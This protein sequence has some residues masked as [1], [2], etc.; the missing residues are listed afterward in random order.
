MQ[1]SHYYSDT[2][3]RTG[4][5]RPFCRTGFWQS[6]SD[7]FCSL[8]DIVL[9]SP[10]RGTVVLFFFIR[11]LTD[12]PRNFTLVTDGREAVFSDFPNKCILL[13]KIVQLH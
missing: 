13:M 9:M 5:V 3:S 2:M 12:S 7:P 10:P 8:H 4:V 1:N 11:P 6:W